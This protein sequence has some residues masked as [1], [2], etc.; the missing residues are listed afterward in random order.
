VLGDERN[1]KSCLPTDLQGCQMANF[2]TKNPTL[3]KFWRVLQWKML[4]YFMSVWSI[5][6]PVVYILWPFGIFYG[7]LEY[8]IWNFFLHFGMLYQVKSGNPADLR[9]RRKE[10]ISSKLF[11]RYR[12]KKVQ[13]YIHTYLLPT[14]VA[15]DIHVC[16]YINM[17]LGYNVFVFTFMSFSLNLF[18]EEGGGATES[19]LKLPSAPFFNSKNQSDSEA[20]SFFEK[21]FC[22]RVKTNIFFW[23]KFACGL[24][25]DA[26]KHIGPLHHSCLTCLMHRY[27][28]FL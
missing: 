9:W 7:Y 28:R 23:A 15:D 10:N 24:D 1:H 8:G 3:G 13:M 27:H 26:H 5:L 21:D 25:V 6:W 11:S 4:V 17:Y 2:R 14:H 18:R 22:Y 12:I 16:I 19:F 20:V